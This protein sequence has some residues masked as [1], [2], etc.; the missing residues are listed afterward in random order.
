MA[1]TPGR[2]PPE[3]VRAALIAAFE[4]GYREKF[5]RTPPD[6]PVELVTLRVTGE[7]AAA[8]APG[9]MPTTPA[10]RRCRRARQP[11]QGR[12]SEEVDGYLD[13]PVFD[14]ATLPAGFHAPGPLLIEDAGSTLVVGPKRPRHARGQR[15]SGH[16]N[17]RNTQHDPSSHA[18]RGFR[19]RPPS[20]WK[21][22]GPAC[23]PW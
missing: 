11:P 2:Q 3:V 16:P 5:G 21:C 15:Q 20:S 4:S 22:S 12:T 23:A 14:R 1:P 6:V 8:R 18:R 9:R 10:R 7:R 17:W 13:T 19:R